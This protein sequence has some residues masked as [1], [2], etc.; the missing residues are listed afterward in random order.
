MHHSVGKDSS[1]QSYDPDWIPKCGTLAGVFCFYC[2]QSLPVAPC[3]CEWSWVGGNNTDAVGRNL[4]E[5]QRWSIITCCVRLCLFCNYVNGAPDNGILGHLHSNMMSV[6]C[7]LFGYWILIV[8]NGVDLFSFLDISAWVCLWLCVC[9]RQFVCMCLFVCVCVC[10]CGGWGEW[11]YR[12]WQ[13]FV[14][15]KLRPNI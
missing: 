12:E 10:V 8:D 15:Q 3:F 4:P 2:C 6:L 9:V 5:V 11:S 7:I 14:N 1:A 13:D